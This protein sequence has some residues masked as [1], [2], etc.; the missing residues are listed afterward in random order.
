MP[1]YYSKDF[2]APAELYANITPSDDTD[3][4][5]LTRQIRVGTGGNLAILN[6][7]GDEVIIPAEVANN[8]AVLD[9][10]ASRIKSTGTDAT[11]IVALY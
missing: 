1:A 10:V 9:I 3:L 7:G 2:S 5:Y 8:G 6:K 11:E 4:P